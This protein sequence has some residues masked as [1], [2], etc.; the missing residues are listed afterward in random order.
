MSASE[1][2]KE[3]I[4]TERG[5]LLESL[6]FDNAWGVEGVR[7]F[8]ETHVWAVWDF[9]SL[10]KGLQRELT[11][12]DVPWVPVGDPEV[13]RFINEIVWGEESDV[14]RH[15]RPMSHFEMYLEAMEKM[16]ADTHPMRSFLRDL[17]SGV[18]M[19]KALSTHAPSKAT[20]DFVAFTFGILEEKALHKSASVFTFGR[21]DL[22]PDMFNVFVS[23]LGSDVGFDHADLLY[24]LERH[25]EVD[26]DEHGPIALRLLDAAVG[27]DGQKKDEAISV[28]IEALRRRRMLWEDIARRIESTHPIVQ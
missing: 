15:G 2:V 7:T 27:N 9:M 26:G 4:A 22:I 12:I 25:I 20:A 14:D 10:V 28:A 1:K 18:S 3:A 6:K 13:R 8:M 17:A 24:Y 21:E 5:L 19:Q 16:G 23:D 11:C